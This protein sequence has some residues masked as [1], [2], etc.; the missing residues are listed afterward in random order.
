MKA[1]FAVLVGT[2]LAG[3]VAQAAPHPIEF[4][5]KVGGAYVLTKARGECASNLVA[6]PVEGSGGVRLAL[7]SP[8]KVPLTTIRYINRGNV[9]EEV[10]TMISF[11]NMILERKIA[12]E[13]LN[14]SRSEP[15]VLS[16]RTFAD[17]AAYTQL[18]TWELVHRGKWTV[19]QG[20]EFVVEYVE[21]CSE[22]QHVYEGIILL[23][24]M[25]HVQFEDDKHR[26]KE[27][28]VEFVTDQLERF[29]EVKTPRSVPVFRITESS[30]DGRINQASD[31]IKTL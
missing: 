19:N 6:K 7:E 20:L 28:H 11:Q 30:V 12:R 4:V 3:S 22:Y 15:Y 1:L 18:W 25:S 23:P 17:I 16:E 27:E 14:A 24:Y 29:L 10:D 8:H 2:I 26:A 5:Q 31:W 9:L 21:T 13:R